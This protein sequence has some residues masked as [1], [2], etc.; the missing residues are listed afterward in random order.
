MDD[1][2]VVMVEMKGL[3]VLVP[4]VADIPFIDEVDSRIDPRSLNWL[5]MLSKKVSIIAAKSTQLLS[6]A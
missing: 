2:A 1:E 3:A 5:S 6:P 4:A